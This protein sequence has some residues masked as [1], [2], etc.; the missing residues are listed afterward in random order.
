[1][2]KLN[3]RQYKIVGEKMLTDFPATF[4]TVCTEGPR[5]RKRSA[6][7]GFSL[8]PKNRL[9]IV[10]IEDRVAR[11]IALYQR[12]LSEPSVLIVSPLS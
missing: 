12:S 5:K 10:V 6:T 7:A 1:M 9:Y 4:G 2:H 3:I 8:R 11:R